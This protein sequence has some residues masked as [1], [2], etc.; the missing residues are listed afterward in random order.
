MQLKLYKNHGNINHC[1]GYLYGDGSFSYQTSIFSLAS[2]VYFCE[3][4]GWKIV[5]PFFST[6]REV[7]NWKIK[8]L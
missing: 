2:S 5:T 1:F 3:E 6:L 7:E 8:N 4:R